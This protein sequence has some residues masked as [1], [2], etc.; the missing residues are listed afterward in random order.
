MADRRETDGRQWFDDMGGLFGGP[1]AGSGDTDDQGLPEG[2]DANKVVATAGYSP[3]DRSG[4][5]HRI[6]R[7][8]V[9]NLKSEHKIVGLSVLF[10][11]LVCTIDAVIESYLLGEKSFFDSLIFDVSTR[12]FFERSVV[13]LSFLAF[14]LIA[15]RVI[16]QWR[17]AEDQLRVNQTMLDNILSAS[18]VGIN[19]VEDGRLV[20]ANPALMEIFGIPD[21]AALL[22]KRAADFYVDEDEFRRV[23]ALVSQCLVKGQLAETDAEMRRIDGSTF[24]A[25]LRVRGVDAGDGGRRFITVVADITA[26][27]RAENLVKESEEYSKALLDSVPAGIMVVDS[28]TQNVVDV[29]SFALGM[30]GDP[31][32]QVIGR[33]SHQFAC[34]EPEP[35]CTDADSQSTGDVLESLLRRSDGKNIPV[36]KTAVPFMR[37]GRSFLLESFVDVTSLVNA[38]QQAEQASRAKSDFLAN[39]SHEIRTPI[40]GI[41]GM[42]ELALNTD[43]TPEQRDYLDAVKVSAESLLRI[44]NDI[45]DFSKMESGKLHLVE[46]PFSI[47][48]TIANTMTILAGQSQKK[49]LELVYYIPPHVPDLVT[50]DP[51]RLSQILVNL[52]GNAIKFTQEGEVAF[53]VDL[54]CETSEEIRL[55][56]SVKDTG[57]GIPADKQA[58]IFQPFEQADSS[59]TRKHGGT[60]LGLSLSSQL[61]EMMGGRIW[62]ESEEGK[63]STFYFSVSLGPAAEQALSTPQNDIADLKGARVLVV[64]DNATNRRILV[65]TLV[66]WGVIASPAASG[67]E[68]LETM[69]KAGEEGKPFEL[70]LTDCMMPGMDGFELTENINKDARLFQAKIIMLTSAGE[71]GDAAR[72]MKLGIS[73]YMPKPIKLSDLQYTVSKVYREPFA[74]DGRSKL[75][76][77]HSIREST[78]RLR[79]LLAE[80]N[81]V[82]QKLAVRMLERMGHAITVVDTGKAAVA[83]TERENFDVVLMDVQMPEMDGLVATTTIRETEKLSG[84]H[85]PII[86]MTA[87]AFEGDREKCLAAGMDAYTSK[88]LNAQELS[89]TM[90]NLLST[91]EVRAHREHGSSDRTVALT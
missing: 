5:R 33:R 60:G 44:I 64:D 7:A 9:D 1:D 12:A 90:E 13:T 17:Q 84:G 42:T 48:D 86:A 67:P 74:G 87:L 70:V 36:L 61:V 47:R 46:I 81:R 65:D 52:G 20:W 68:A 66:H 58:R 22:G 21:P 3:Q 88:P 24:H 37:R 54:E 56:F 69:V 79:V 6:R 4:L 15:G 28:V 59:T 27:K 80:D 82:N 78:R 71:R 43:L 18:P 57:I 38:R 55:L 10:L 11:A 76:T 41:M 35:I 30:I 72:C 32:E 45:L 83:A 85:T 14:G 26:R 19:C 62:L 34:V 50:G 77:R 91:L 63:G 25:A 39:M 75:I 89:E 31:R 8:I 23:R 2:R 49:A 40:H 16:S 51:G 53:N 29:N 73:A